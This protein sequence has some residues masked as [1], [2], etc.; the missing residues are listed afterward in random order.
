[1]FGSSEITT[2]LMLNNCYISFV[3]LDHRKDRLDHM[4]AELTRIGIDAVRTRGRMPHEFTDNRKVEVM[5]KRTPG[6][7]G[8]HFSQVKV[9]QDALKLG[10]H[11][12]V[13][14][15]DLI[16]CSD[17]KER[18][19]HIERFL[20]GKEWDVFWLGG[21]FHVNPPYWH[22]AGHSHQL[23][24]CS[25]TL[26]RDAQVTE[27]PRVM[28]TYGAFST[29]AYI[30]NQ[31]SIDKILKLFD[32]HL[33]TSIGIDWLFIK[34]EPQLKTFAFV[35][36]CVKQMDNAS[37]IGIGQNGKPAITK[38]S[39]FAMLGPYW[40]QDRMEQFNPETFN[41]AEAR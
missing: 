12:F 27:D 39:G 18:I 6:A 29:F 21:T 32:K 30:V 31:H 38:F 19:S 17:F 10:K 16:F 14:E 24:D 1:V 40:W 23:R 41:W 25:C 3:N 34:L 36:G 37:D 28:R 11:A 2:D 35:P 7:I 22:K 15:D 9:M 13:M 33:H 8:C 26:G 20:D 4:T 5:R